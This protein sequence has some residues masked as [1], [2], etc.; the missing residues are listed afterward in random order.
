MRRR[1]NEKVKGTELRA[2]L[3]QVEGKV[4]PKGRAE[5]GQAGE[6]TAK[7]GVQAGQKGRGRGNRAQA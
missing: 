5:K 3:N 7:V 4:Q 2:M 6:E 1:E